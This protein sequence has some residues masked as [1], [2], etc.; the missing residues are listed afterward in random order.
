M[1]LKFAIIQAEVG[2]GIA[3]I[4]DTTILERPSQ[5]LVIQCSKKKL[6][7]YEILE[8]FLAKSNLRFFY[9]YNR[10]AS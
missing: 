7:L 6:D 1:T 9:T 2:N 10:Q 4:L 8:I 3:Y 5:T